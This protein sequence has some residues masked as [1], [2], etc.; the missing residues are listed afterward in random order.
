[1]GPDDPLFRIYIFI[2]TKVRRKYFNTLRENNFY[3]VHK[4]MY[5]GVFIYKLNKVVYILIQS[6]I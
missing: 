1:M 3:A 2:L 4:Y 5:K 6:V